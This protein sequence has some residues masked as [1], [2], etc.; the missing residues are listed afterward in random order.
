MA[1]PETIPFSRSSKR[2]LFQLLPWA[3][4]EERKRHAAGPVKIGVGYI[5]SKITLFK[6]SKL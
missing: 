3:I 4:T 6:I 5:Y 2:E 1:E